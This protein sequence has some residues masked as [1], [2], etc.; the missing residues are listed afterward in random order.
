[1][2]AC[3]GYTIWFEVFHVYILSFHTVDENMNIEI[4]VFHS[5]INF[6]EYLCDDEH[7]SFLFDKW[8]KYTKV[9]LKEG[10]TIEIF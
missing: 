2:I 3:L 10:S 7:P 6:S 5:V 9:E 4:L 1:M 8:E